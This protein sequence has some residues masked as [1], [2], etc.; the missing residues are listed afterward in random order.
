MQLPYMLLHV[1]PLLCSQV[2]QYSAATGHIIVVLL[3]KMCQSLQQCSATANINNLTNALLVHTT[4]MLFI[5]IM[6]PNQAIPQA[7][8]SM[9]RRASVWLRTRT[10]PQCVGL[11]TDCNKPVRVVGCQHAVL[12]QPG[13]Q[14]CN[15]ILYTSLSHACS[16]QQGLG[17]SDHQQHPKS[18]PEQTAACKARP[19]LRC[20]ALLHSC[21]ISA[22]HLPT[23]CQ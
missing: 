11:V 2:Q 17:N 4:S 14:Q 18:S 10:Q 12:Q 5:I 19:C 22:E 3:L 13:S 23:T 7:C 21:A 8:C 1:L 16:L 20:P 6:L 9:S 15:Q